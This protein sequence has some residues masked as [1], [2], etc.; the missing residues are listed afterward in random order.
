MKIFLAVVSGFALTLSVFATGAMLAVTYLAVPALERGPGPDTASAWTMEPQRV[1]GDGDLERVEP[2]AIAATNAAER[3]A[4]AGN[5]AQ[6]AAAGVAEAAET[7]DGQLDMTT[8]AAIPAEAA[9]D[10]EAERRDAE[11][12][13]L[14]SA[15]LDWCSSHFRSYR[16]DDNSYQPYSGGRQACESPYLADLEALDAGSAEM[17]GGETGLVTGLVEAVLDS[18]DALAGENGTGDRGYAEADMEFFVEEPRGQ[19]RPAGLTRDHIQS[20]FDRYRSYRPEDNS[21]QPFGGGPRRQC[22]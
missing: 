14:I 12:Q 20:C 21:Y 10:P 4:Q 11:A 9:A 8:T 18:D 6:A 19:L 3:P 15:H 1:N 5:E 22:R 7:G 2:R 13:M 16:P 17:G